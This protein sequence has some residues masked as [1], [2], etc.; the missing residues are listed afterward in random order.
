VQTIES[1]FAIFA[2]LTSSISPVGLVVNYFFFLSTCFLA[3]QF[4][5]QALDVLECG[6]RCQSPPLVAFALELLEQ[7]LAPRLLLAGSPQQLAALSEDAL[8]AMLVS[9]YPPPPY[10]IYCTASLAP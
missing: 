2:C 7:D 10:P 5:N 3:S 8:C 9:A 6:C 1:A 4:S